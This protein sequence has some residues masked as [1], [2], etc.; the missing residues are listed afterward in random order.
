MIHREREMSTFCESIA[1]A[2]HANRPYLLPLLAWMVPSPPRGQ[3]QRKKRPSQT[4][5]LALFDIVP[6]LVEARNYLRSWEPTHHDVGK[7]EQEIRCLTSLPPNSNPPWSRADGSKSIETWRFFR[8]MSSGGF[9]SFSG[10]LA[11]LCPREWWCFG[12]TG[13]LNPV[14]GNLVGE[15]D[16]E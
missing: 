10:N 5:Y 16:S 3:R 4:V 12:V 11:L 7:P 13:R 2:A 1:S 6:R 15:M 14:E 9:M 8:G